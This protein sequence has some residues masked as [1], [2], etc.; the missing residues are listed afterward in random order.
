[1]GLFFRFYNSETTQLRNSFCLCFGFTFW[2]NLAGCC[3]FAHPW[4]FTNLGKLY[5]QVRILDREKSPSSYLSLA[6]KI[7]KYIY[8]TLTIHENLSISCCNV[9]HD[10]WHFANNFFFFEYLEAHVRRPYISQRRDPH[11]VKFISFGKKI[12]PNVPRTQ[13]LHLRDL[14]SLFLCLPS[15]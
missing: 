4:F 8:E 3:C 14:P 1:M 13:H 9:P 6:L 7:V 11:P 15:R 5:S 12:P 10:I 2:F